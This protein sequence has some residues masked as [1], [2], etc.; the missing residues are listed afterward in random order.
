MAALGVPMQR[1]AE[2]VATWAIQRPALV[3]RL[4]RGIREGAA[5]IQ[6]EAVELPTAL[7]VPEGPVARTAKTWSNKARAVEISAR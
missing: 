5:V 1:A 3:V 2:L 7:V 6:R 4:E